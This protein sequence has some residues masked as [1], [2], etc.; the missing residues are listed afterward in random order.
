MSPA[1]QMQKGIRRS[2]IRIKIH[3]SHLQP[4]NLPE[5]SHLQKEAEHEPRL[6]P[7]MKEE[8]GP[9]TLSPMSHPTQNDRQN[10]N[11]C[12][13]LRWLSQMNKDLSQ[14]DETRPQPGPR[15]RTLSMPQEKK[16]SE[17]KFQKK[18]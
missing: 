5:A 15:S 8:C 10:P 1:M 9:N 11:P 12:D 7:Q 17:K 3:A 18:S 14:N 13:F 4:E 6:N 2:S 16:G